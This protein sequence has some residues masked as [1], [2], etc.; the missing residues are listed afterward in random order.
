MELSPAARNSRQTSC[1]TYSRLASASERAPPAAIIT[2]ASCACSTVIGFLGNLGSTWP[3]ITAIMKS[4]PSEA[5]ERQTLRVLEPTEELLEPLALLI[6]QR[7]TARQHRHHAVPLQPG[8][9]SQHATATIHR[10]GFAVRI[11]RLRRDLISVFKHFGE[12]EALGFWQRSG[13]LH[14]GIR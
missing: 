14:C 1:Q 7:S 8:Q 4:R 11:P 9:S 2:R 3:A 13:C 10:S 6:G 12:L 5:F